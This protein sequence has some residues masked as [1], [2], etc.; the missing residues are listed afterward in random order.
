VQV[1][2]FEVDTGSF[3]LQ[4][5]S[6]KQVADKV[7]FMNHFPVKRDVETLQSLFLRCRIEVS[8]QL[9]VLCFHLNL[10]VRSAGD[11]R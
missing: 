7:L 4:S 5:I 9:Q 10:A 2:F 1:I 3:R 11:Y 6:N 8:D